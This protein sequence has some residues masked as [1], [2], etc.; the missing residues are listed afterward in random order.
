MDVATSPTLNFPLPSST[1]SEVRNPAPFGL[2]QYYGF[3]QPYDPGPTGSAANE[4]NQS[5]GPNGNGVGLGIGLALPPLRCPPPDRPFASSNPASSIST[6]TATTASSYF[7]LNQP[8]P[9]TYP[10]HSSSSTSSEQ[11]YTPTTS[12][13]YS[14]SAYLTPP[15]TNPDGQATSLPSLNLPGVTSL[16]PQPP[17]IQLPLPTTVEPKTFSQWS[18]TGPGLGRGLDLRGS[19]SS[20]SLRDSRFSVSPLSGAALSISR[21]TSVESEYPRPG[22]PGGPDVVGHHAHHHHHRHPLTTVIPN[23][24]A[25]DAATIVVYGGRG[26]PEPGEVGITREGD[27]FFTDEAEVKQSAYVSDLYSPR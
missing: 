1:G 18:S 3:S 25:Y 11:I 10:G 27:I 26:G 9:H 2:Q 16:F 19:T 24:D 5:S 8:P 17:P 4:N 21:S 7:G 23:M 13:G 20:L 22:G 6:S 14:Q 15:A 12:G